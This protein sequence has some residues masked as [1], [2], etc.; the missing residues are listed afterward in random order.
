MVGELIDTIEYDYT[1]F[2]LSM[3]CFWCKITRG[4]LV[5]KEH[6]DAKWLDKAGLDSVNWL[7]ADNTLIDKIRRVL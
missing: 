7:P 4:N 3:D 5:L 1:T 6:E 2:Y